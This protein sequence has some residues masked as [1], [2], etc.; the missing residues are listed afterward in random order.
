MNTNLF[1]LNI[2]VTVI[3]LAIVVD[4]QTEWLWME[5]ANFTL[6]IARIQYEYNI[7]SGLTLLAS[8]A[9]A[10]FRSLSCKWLQISVINESA[11]VQLISL[12]LVVYAGYG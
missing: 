11:S 5:G 12:P 1:P 9:I 2:D 4:A 7:M 3:I 6:V 8:V 10:C